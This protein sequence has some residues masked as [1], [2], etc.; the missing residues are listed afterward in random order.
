MIKCCNA[1]IVDVVLC[2]SISYRQWCPSLGLVALECGYS[3][4]DTV[5]QVQAQD[6]PLLFKVCALCLS[7][8]MEIQQIKDESR[9]AANGDIC[10]S[11]V[12]LT[13]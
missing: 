7:V 4:M 6:L 1:L 13:N 8:C 11:I 12:S 3:M 9:T 5:K 2:I 10:R